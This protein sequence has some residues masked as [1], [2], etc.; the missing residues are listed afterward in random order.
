[1]ENQ[2]T[3]YKLRFFTNISHEFR[4]PL[5]IIKGDMDRLK[6]VDKVPG[7]MKQ[8]LS[9]MAKSVERMMRLINQLLEFRKMQNDKLQLALEKTDVIAFLQDIFLNFNNIAE[10][11]HINFMFLPFDRVT[12]CM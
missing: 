4:T 1:M 11:K 2:L 10:G 8:P 3:E 12:R 6:T 5:T 7:E 9:S